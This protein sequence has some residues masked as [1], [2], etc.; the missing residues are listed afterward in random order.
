MRGHL[1]R[2][3]AAAADTFEKCDSVSH[4]VMSDSLQPHGLQP[5]RILCPWD[6]L[7]KDTGVGCHALLQGISLTERLNPSLLPC[8]QIL[9]HLSHPGSPYIS[10]TQYFLSFVWFQHQ[11]WWTAPLQADSH[12][13]GLITVHTQ[14]FS[15]TKGTCSRSVGES[16]SP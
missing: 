13:S 12:T 7:G 11:P 8:R 1:P 16:A 9:Y 4:S 6:S 15:K 2:R 10:C 14:H 3:A 5:T